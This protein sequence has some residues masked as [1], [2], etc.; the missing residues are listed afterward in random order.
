MKRFFIVALALLMLS[1]SVPASFAADDITGHWAENDIRTLANKGIMKGDG[2][3]TYRPEDAVS[4]AEFT[5]LMVRALEYHADQPTMEVASTQGAESIY[6]DVSLDDWFYSDVI[7]ATEAG[8]I[9][10]YDNGTF[11]PNKKISRQEMAV[12][13]K[14]ALESKGVIL[15]PTPLA[16]TDKFKIGNYY[17]EAVAK[18]VNAG[19]M[20]G[21]NN[22]FS[23]LAN[24]KRAE[25]AAVVNRIL[26]LLNDD[27]GYQIV[28]L[29][30]DGS[31]RKIR[32][33]A[34]YQS[35]LEN[36]AANQAIMEADRF[37]YI[38]NGMAVSNAVT[39]I[40]DSPTL[41]GSSRTYVSGGT[42]FK[43]I[44]V[45]KDW[46]KI[47]LNGITGYVS[48]KNV[49]LIPTPLIKD[50]SSY[51][52]K[53]ND[54]YHYL[55]NPL[56]HTK[57]PLLVGKVP[58]FMVEGKKYYSD[59][60]IK[61]TD[62]NGNLVGE[63]AIRFNRINL[64]STTQ[65]SAEQLDQYLLDNYPQSFADKLAQ[66]LMDEKDFSSEEATE[67]AAISPLA[68]LGVTFKEMEA[69]YGINALYLM[70]HAIHESA[71]GTSRIAQLKNNLYGINATDTNTEENADAYA[72]FEDSVKR[73]AQFIAVGNKGNDGYLQEKSWKYNG[74]FLG[75]KTKGMNV[76]YASDPYWGE[77]IAGH[78]YRADSYLGGLDSM[79]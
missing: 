43:L 75:N 10:G 45:N 1:M 8:L 73:A 13:A 23:P 72:S 27:L 36:L 31:T 74:S 40:Y 54:L 9:F 4:R 37:V 67:I 7:S 28:Q 16:F 44:E 6:T 26:T 39:N 35:A 58:E 78:M 29:N 47:S 70:A 20:G 62:I 53:G 63:E 30:A 71:W 46:V 60:G 12:I 19:I 50:R 24:S 69:N 56:N 66:L 51:E 64:L 77:K 25:T 15:S 38:Q 3:G 42:E 17:V 21:Y 33:Y 48:P 14:R 68:G 2:G 49:N 22:Q 55:Y 18:V 59:D 11:G 34:N 79:E 32:E 65:Y 52:R 5:A 57:A 61:Y 41:V 76:K